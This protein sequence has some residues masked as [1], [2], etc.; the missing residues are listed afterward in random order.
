LSNDTLDRV[1]RITRNHLGVPLEAVFPE[2]SFVDDLEADS[3]D[4]AELMI[5]FEEAFQVEIP[6][7]K[8]EHITTVQNAVDFIEIKMK[9]GPSADPVARSA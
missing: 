3:L 7:A 6:Q 4:K 2:A 5:A 9:G 1:M 8:A